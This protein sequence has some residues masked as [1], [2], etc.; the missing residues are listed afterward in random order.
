MGL[1][2]PCKVHFQ[3]VQQ[4]VS[5]PFFAPTP[6]LCADTYFFVPTP[7]YLIPH[8][9]LPTL[10]PATLR[11]HLILCTHTCFFLPEIA[12]SHQTKLFWSSRVS[13]SDQLAIKNFK[14]NVLQKYISLS[15][16]WPNFNFCTIYNHNNMRLNYFDF[17]LITI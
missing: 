4:P 12:Y 8:L 6:A 5:L 2:E 3:T 7:A 14:V 11:T 13:P 16:I 10:T 17:P 15:Q 1:I 9:L